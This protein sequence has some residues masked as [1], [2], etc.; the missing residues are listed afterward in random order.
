ME[1][2]NTQQGALISLTRSL[3]GDFDIDAILSNSA[4]YLN[5][6]LFLTYL[7]VAVFIMLSMFLAILGEAQGI[8][9]EMQSKK[10]RKGIFDEWYEFVDQTSGQVARKIKRA[11]ANKQDAGEVAAEEARTAED[12][13]K[14]EEELKRK[15]EI[16]RERAPARRKDV[17]RVAD[18]V[19]ATIRAELGSLVDS[20][21]HG[22]GALAH[23][24]SAASGA[25]G[26]TASEQRLVEMVEQSIETRVLP[27][28]LKQV[29]A[30]LA[31]ATG[32]NPDGG[33]PARTLTSSASACACGAGDVPSAGRMALERA[34]G[35]AAGA[36]EGAVRMTRHRRNPR[37]TN[38]LLPP[39]R[40][41]LGGGLGAA[42]SC[43]GHEVV[44]PFGAPTSGLAASAIHEDGLSPDLPLDRC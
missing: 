5:T 32:L 4:D 11:R 26:P 35:A 40:D 10:S 8:A 1:R 25:R 16:L 43:D 33:V 9:R 24:T 3:F 13:A 37:R 21:E 39:G 28:L 18:I 7:F 6:I 17:V 41:P 14:A 19:A 31:L 44:E 36:A 30:R 38:G 12:L 34:A 42:A 15:D 29:D 2:F 20:I 27:R 22:G 23:G